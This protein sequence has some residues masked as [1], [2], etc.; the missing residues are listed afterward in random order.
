M[1]FCLSVVHAV[2]QEAAENNQQVVFC[3]A[4]R[5]TSAHERHHL[6]Y[7]CKTD[8]SLTM[9]RAVI[10]NTDRNFILEIR[11]VWTE[12]RQD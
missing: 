9:H 11:V 4:D 10:L 1:E 3:R 8:R 7:Y 5:R 12:N 6:S 2:M